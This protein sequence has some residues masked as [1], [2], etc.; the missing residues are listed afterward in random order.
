MFVC[1][2]KSKKRIEGSI[3]YEYSF[4]CL[5]PKRDALP[6]IREEMGT[7]KS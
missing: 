3:F 1:V 7:A 4:Y 6:K 5:C 2:K